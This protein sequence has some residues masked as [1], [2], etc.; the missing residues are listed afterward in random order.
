MFPHSTTAS[1]YQVSGPLKTNMEISPFEQTWLLIG[2][3]L[4]LLYWIQY[5]ILHLNALLDC[6]TPVAPFTNMV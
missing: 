5:Y 2:I 6:G 4:Y 3:W 1:I